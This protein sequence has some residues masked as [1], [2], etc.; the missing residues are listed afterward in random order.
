MNG[1]RD[2]VLKKE[3]EELEAKFPGRFQVT[4]TLSRGYEGTSDE[5]RF[6]KGYINKAVLQEAIAR[7]ESG[8]WGDVKGTKVWLCGPPAME[9]AVAGKTGVLAELGVSG[10]MVH[11]F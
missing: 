6:Q 9:S 5:K 4:Y 8:S 7:C 11:K 3:L 1:T 2:I 10:K